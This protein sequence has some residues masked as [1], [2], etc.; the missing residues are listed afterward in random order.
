MKEIKHFSDSSEYNIY[1]NQ[2]LWKAWVMCCYIATT[3]KYPITK[4]ASVVLWRKDWSIKNSD[5]EKDFG[6]NVHIVL[7]ILFQRC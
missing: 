1:G 3:K 4:K 2:W 6:L 7:L 5:T